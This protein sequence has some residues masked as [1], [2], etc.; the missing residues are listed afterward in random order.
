M[1]VLVQRYYT[2]VHSH[3]ANK[4]Q[5]PIG[6][7]ARQV[8]MRGGSHYAVLATSRCLRHA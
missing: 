6:P 8:S 3:D 7:G 5:A 1:P 2:C 4:H